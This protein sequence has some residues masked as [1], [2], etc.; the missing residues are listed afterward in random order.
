MKHKKGWPWQLLKHDERSQLNRANV[1]R[2]TFVYIGFGCVIFV[3]TLFILSLSL[4]RS[5][6]PSMINAMSGAVNKYATQQKKE[7]IQH[8]HNT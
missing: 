3:F 7:R 4:S 1:I 6:F 8:T 5:N 2:V